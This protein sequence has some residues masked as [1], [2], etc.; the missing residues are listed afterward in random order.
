MSA[1]QG[2][3]QVTYFVV[4]LN[5]AFGETQGT[6]AGSTTGTATSAAPSATQTTTGLAGGDTATGPLGAGDEVLLPFSAFEPVVVGGAGT[7]T[8]DDADN[9]ALTLTIDDQ[10]LASAPVF[11]RDSIDFMAATWDDQWRAFW[12][13]QGLT[14]PVTGEGEDAA[15]G[16]ETVLLGETFEG[17][18]VVNTNDDDLGEVEDFI[19][20]TQTGEF[21]YA[22]LATGGFLG[23]GE[24]L[25]PV[26]MSMV[27]WMVDEDT[28]TDPSQREVDDVGQILINIPEDAFENAPAFDSLDDLDT[29]MTDW[30]TDI[31]AFWQTYIK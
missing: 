1:G 29:S 7:T 5:T 23:L 2:G 31:T 25:I 30:D 14:I 26:P 17:I 8:G 9:P 10:V 3:A 27:Y 24:K 21:R 20:D 19:L 11:D 22:I 15:A 6:G 4:E 28:L 18:N 12:S 16:V 13:G